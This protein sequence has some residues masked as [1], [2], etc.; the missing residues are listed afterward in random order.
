MPFN[1][2]FWTAASPECQRITIAAAC[3]EH[4]KQICIGRFAPVWLRRF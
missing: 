2:E 1:I 3:W 4:A